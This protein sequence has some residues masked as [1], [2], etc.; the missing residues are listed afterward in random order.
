[1]TAVTITRPAQAWA[2]ALA[3]ILAVLE[4]ADP[5]T[6]AGIAAVRAAWPTNRDTA[7]A[8]IRACVF[9]RQHRA[10]AVAIQYRIRFRRADRRLGCPHRVPSTVIVRADGTPVET[11]PDA[12]CAYVDRHF[13]TT[14]PR[15]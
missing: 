11:A 12:L 14:E 7:V 2:P 3:D 10:S 8:W 6:A 9:A 5:S 1:M 13:E 4:G 15:R